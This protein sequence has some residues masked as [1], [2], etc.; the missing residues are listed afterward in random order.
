MRNNIIKTIETNIK[1]DSI[2]I[3]EMQMYDRIQV[4]K[5]F[6]SK[7]TVDDLNY[8]VANGCLNI[9]ESVFSSSKA[10]KYRDKL[11]KK[12]MEMVDFK[13]KIEGNLII[14]VQ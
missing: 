14:L 11:I 8:L 10:I 7:D 4:N 3:K 13:Y 1:V 5:H 2:I 12:V 9:D 6:L